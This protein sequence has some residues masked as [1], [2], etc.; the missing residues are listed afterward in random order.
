MVIT[1]VYF[2]HYDLS[3]NLEQSLLSTLI[4]VEKSWV[5]LRIF[6]WIGCFMMKP[7][8]IV[9]ELEMSYSIGL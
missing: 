9:E 2:W 3:M 5:L 1:A 7:S 4:F 6:K 8:S